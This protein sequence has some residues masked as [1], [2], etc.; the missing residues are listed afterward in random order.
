MEHRKYGLYIVAVAISFLIPPNSAKADIFADCAA[1]IEQGD[2]E[3]IRS[4]SE[5]M[6][7][8][9]TIDVRNWKLAEKCVSAALESPY[10]YIP[11]SGTFVE[12]KQYQ[13]EIERQES[14]KAAKMEAARK[15]EAERMAQLQAEAELKAKLRMRA[16]A[17]ENLNRRLI[18][19]DIQSVC[20]ELYS[21]DLASAMTN[22]VCV[23]SFRANGHPNLTDAALSAGLFSQD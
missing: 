10:R 21:Q 13:A 2:A 7:R 9:N 1:A 15:R 12:E 11:T 17:I 18:A 22:A 16:E 5:R 6:Q 3:T 8:F 14:E 23:D 4:L 20:K 19:E